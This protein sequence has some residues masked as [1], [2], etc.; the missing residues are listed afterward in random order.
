MP[1]I[2]N[3]GEAAASGDSSQQNS[4]SASQVELEHLLPDDGETRFEISDD[5]EVE[6]QR[7]GL[8]AQEQARPRERRNW[9]SV[10]M[11]GPEKPIEP[12][13]T[14]IFP[15]LQTFPT[16]FWQSRS[17]RT[18]KLAVCGYLVIW[19]LVFY[20]LANASALAKPFIDEEPV[21]LIGCGQ[22]RQIWRG[23]DSYCGIDGEYCVHPEGQEI[24][25][26]CVADCRKESWTYAQV[27]VGDYGSIY[28]PYVIGSNNSYRADSFVCGAAVHHGAISDITGGCGIIR[29]KGRASGFN[30]STQNGITSLEYDGDFVDSFEFVDIPK[31]SKCKGCK[32]L[33]HVTVGFNVV[34]SYIYGYFVSHPA[35]FLWPMFLVGFWT[36]VLAS[37]PPLQFDA[38]SNVL[39]N[40]E[41][42]SLAARR[43][44][45][46]MLCAY[47]LYVYAVRPQ[48][49]NLDA[50][51]SRAVFWVSF[52]WI[53]I[54]ENYVFGLL[55][56]DRLTVEDLNKQAGAWTAL[57]IIVTVI[58]SIAI[59]Q[60]YTIWRMGKFSPY[61]KLYGC[62]VLGLL[63][64]SFVPHQTLRIHHYIM[65]LLLLPG[66]GFKT[67]PSL[68]YQG[69]L[70]G[71]FISG[72]SRWGFDSIIQTYEQLRRGAPLLYGGV[73]EL[74]Q[75][76]VS[77]NLTSI[78]WTPAITNASSTLWDRFSLV[79]NDVER[80]R[81]SLPEFNLTLV[82]DTA[83]YYI[84]V[85][86]AS[87]DM[88]GDYTKAGILDIANGN[89]TAPAEG[90]I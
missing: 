33:R 31:D 3:E 47:V 38:P 51:L 18:F 54:L 27:P 84:R 56:I 4:A 41:L 64:L 12:H 26:K 19:A 20:F 65:A 2:M 37:N 52:F 8:E 57:F 53:G 40:A 32:D 28:R 87:A 13:V 34:A 86:F 15:G 69:I 78:L 82:P 35:L 60:A 1:T 67:T 66:T 50:H 49:K 7:D 88:T 72:V 74:A 46:G 58:L 85:A 43:L 63:L 24:R 42:V 6:E 29:F 36:V 81:G 45:P 77:N 16:K 61:I 48:L 71:L 59:G 30:S 68:A 21:Q 73:P 75:P 17:K 5:E 10:L 11:D 83:V 76:I 89:W 23:R 70:M 80:Y 14:L 62:F 9:F 25:F 55:P 90:V 44:L 22:S 79:V 39:Q